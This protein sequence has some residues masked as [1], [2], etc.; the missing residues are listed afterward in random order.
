MTYL[1]GSANRILFFGVTEGERTTDDPGE[2][3]REEMW[4]VR[5]VSTHISHVSSASTTECSS[6]VTGDVL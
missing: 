3:Q 1:V 4:Q 2:I 5:S 6:S